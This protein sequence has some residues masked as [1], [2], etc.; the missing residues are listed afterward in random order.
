MKKIA[1]TI[2]MAFFAALLMV[3]QPAEAQ[4]RKQSKDAKKEAKKLENEG[5]KTMSLPIVRQLEQFYVKMDQTDKDGQPFYL[6]A[7]QIGV[8]NS[9]AAAKMT[10]TNNCKID[11]A[12]EIRSSVMSEA[13][14]HLANDMR[15][16]EEA[17]SITESL[18][19]STM[20]VAEK[21]NKVIVAQEYYKVLDN[22]NFEVHVVLL[23][24]TNSIREALLDEAREQLRKSLNNFKPEYDRILESIINSGVK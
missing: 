23:Y 20:L 14:N 12:K 15:N 1:L 9:Y 24:S 22:K 10:A 2:G 11:L 4:T 8:G 19:R 13:K 17:S 6:M 7:S 5:F 21:L 18:E 16:A 3:G